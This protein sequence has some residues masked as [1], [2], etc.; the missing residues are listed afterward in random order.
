VSTTPEGDVR[1]GSLERLCGPR[2][3]GLAVVFLGVLSTWNAR[4]AK[5]ATKAPERTFEQGAQDVEP[6][7]DAAEPELRE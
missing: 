5:T 4:R 1:R 3:R 6:E 2:A 7:V